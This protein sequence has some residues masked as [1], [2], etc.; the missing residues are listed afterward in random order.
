MISSKSRIVFWNILLV[1]LFLRPFLSEYAFL[2]LGAQ[3]NLLL[4]LCALIYFFISGN[5]FAFSTYFDF[6]PV[7]FIA[8]ALISMFFSGYTIWSLLEL[9]FFF[10]NIMIFYIVSRISS[11]QIDNLIKI[12][13]IASCIISI[14]AIY[15]Y[16]I[17]IDATIEYLKRMGYGNKSHLAVLGRKRV[18]GTFVSP[19]IFASY[20]AMMVFTGLGLVTSCRKAER[21]AYITG[22]LLA[23]AALILT[24]SI[25][26]F[27]AFIITFILFIVWSGRVTGFKQPVLKYAG[28]GLVILSVIA[29][30]I[31]SGSRVLQFADLS[32]P[33]NSLVQRLYYWKASLSMIKD[34]PFFGI[35]WRKF[36]VLYEAFKPLSA[37]TSHYS[38]N[39]FLQIT[40]ETGL[41]GAGIFLLMVI[42]FFKKGIKVIQDNNNS[43]QLLIGL[44][45]AGC[46]FIIHNL[47]DLS[48]YFAQVS[49]FWW[50]VLGVFANLSSKPECK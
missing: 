11:K 7:L 49:F 1:L 5:K 37:N 9:F 18:F 6:L 50:I 30:F 40:A 3:Y 35:G 41:L 27:I 14:Y 43:R 21:A 8:S 39:V 24:K 4:I 16:F 46:F 28:L 44:Y 25:G 33:N 20:L 22:V 17:G 13:F 10:P 19:N 26:G 23:I 29:F 47:F 15:Q 2:T 42:D 32:N 48:F 36:G 45:C 38:H 31:F 12:L 34:S